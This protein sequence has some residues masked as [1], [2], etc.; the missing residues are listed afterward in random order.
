M[1]HE[2]ERLQASHLKILDLALQGL[3]RTEIAEA[4]G[5]TP[6]GIGLIMR[7]PVFQGQL[8]RRRL[9]YESKKDEAQVELE[10]TAEQILTQCAHTAA[11]V[12]RDLLESKDE[13]VRQASAKDI[14]DRVG[15]SRKATIE[16]RDVSIQVELR[17]D[18]LERIAKFASLTGNPIELPELGAELQG[19]SNELT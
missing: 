8:A 18:D 17:G 15:V 4:T 19:D 12:Q 7:A 5:R 9:E 3:T 14:L 2:I 1:P 6:E 10:L 11:T 16:S 13:R